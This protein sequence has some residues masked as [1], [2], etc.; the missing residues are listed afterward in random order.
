MWTQNQMGYFHVRRRIRLHLEDVQCRSRESL[1]AKSG[2][3]CLVVDD[4]AARRIDEKRVR[5]HAV[6]AT[7]VDQMSR[8][9][10]EGQMK[11][12]DVGLGKDL[13]KADA[14]HPESLSFRAV[15]ARIA[16]DEARP[17]D[18]QALRRQPANS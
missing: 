12:K 7:G 10:V 14:L 1:R 5:L 4:A 9:L 18:L 3:Q 17:E 2:H 6:E 11:G 13:L 15:P 16:G 8:R